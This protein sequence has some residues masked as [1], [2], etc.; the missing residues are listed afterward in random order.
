MTACDL[1]PGV[2]PVDR[3]R[4]LVGRL[5]AAVHAH[6][7]VEALRGR[8]TRRRTTGRRGSCRGRAARCTIP[9]K[10]SGASVTQRSSSA[11]AASGSIIGSLATSFSRSGACA[12]VLGAG[13]VERLA[14]RGR[15]VAVEQRPLLARAGREHHGDVD[16][17]EVHV[18]RGAAP[19]RTCPRG[20]P[21]GRSRVVLGPGATSRGLPPPRLHPAAG[22][23]GVGAPSCGR[24]RRACWGRNR[25]G[26]PPAPVDRLA[27]VPVGVDH[28]VAVSTHRQTPF[29]GPAASPGLS[30]AGGDV[31]LAGQ[32]LAGL[33][34][35]EVVDEGIEQDV[36]ARPACSTRCA[37]SAGPAGARTSSGPRAA[38]RGPPR[39][40]T[41]SRRVPSSSAARSASWSM[42][43][44]RAMFTRWTPGFI[45]VERVGIDQAVGLDRRGRREHHMVG[46][47]QQIGEP[48]RDLDSGR[49]R[50]RSCG[51]ARRRACRR[52]RPVGDG[53][54]MP[55]R[56][57]SRACARE[58]ARARRSAT[59]PSSRARHESGIC[60]SN[61][62]I[63][64]ST[65][66]EI[67]T[68]LGA[69]GARQG[70]AVEQVEREGLSTPVPTVCT[71]CTPRVEHLVE[72][73]GCPTPGSAARHPALRR[74]G[75]P[76]SGSRQRRR[77][78]RPLRCE[79]RGRHRGGRALSCEARYRHRQA[80]ENGATIAERILDAI[81]DLGPGVLHAVAFFLAFAECALFMDLVVPGE[82]GMVVAGAAGGPRRRPAA[83]DDPG[84][85]ARRDR[86]R[87]SELLGGSPLG[88]AVDPA[89][90]AATA[91][92]RAPSGALAGVLRGAGRC[93]RLLRAVRGCGARRRAGGGRHVE[94]GVPAVSA[95]ER[96]GVDRVD[97]T[98]WCRP[99]T[100]SAA[101]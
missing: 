63:T 97:Q 25:V 96:A 41:P 75:R 46:R 84:G 21:A 66:S 91:A 32:L 8:P 76:R 89:V 13:V 93:R 71:H 14:Q 73:R 10:T 22:Q 44:P 62:S 72:V 100:C 69:A 87:L 45:F 33:V 60:F 65:H 34:A 70:L 39:P 3:E 17:L 53:R 64:A 2:E 52:H 18:A 90:G 94:N 86:G 68:A 15:E 77:Q 47:A 58:A 88:S 20:M 27:A 42:S 12:R 95:L 101:M 11:A 98:R 55:P 49:G 92:A 28:V 37:G 31:D 50:A 26:M 57:T 16:A 40:A 48:A 78:A 1:E 29:S 6:R 79:R 4:H 67:G 85:G 35:A 23:P 43:A 36:A 59:A 30:V 19:G 81:A 56:P 82:A 51:G 38:A 74:A 80:A 24:R 99:A 83:D 7:D 9:T 54:P 61:A 5:A